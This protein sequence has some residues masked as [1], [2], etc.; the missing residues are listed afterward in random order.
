MTGHID[1]R[2][3]FS[4]RRSN[5]VHVAISVKGDILIGSENT[6]QLRR[7]DKARYVPHCVT[8]FL[9]ELPQEQQLC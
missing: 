7:Y 2:E 8:E 1:Q 4:E 6:V 3:L 9:R 5:E